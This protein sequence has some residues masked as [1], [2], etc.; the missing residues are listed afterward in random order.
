MGPSCSAGFCRE[1]DI[2]HMRAG[3]KGDVTTEVGGDVTTEVG[4]DVTVS[5][6]G[7]GNE[8]KGSRFKREPAAFSEDQLWQGLPVIAIPRTPGHV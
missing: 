3:G 1:V 4:G 7:C 2:A 6:S 8:E 5:F